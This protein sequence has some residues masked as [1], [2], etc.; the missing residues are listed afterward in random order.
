MHLVH[1]ELR[2]GARTQPSHSPMAISTSPSR[3]TS[4]R[5]V[6]VLLKVTARGN[7]SVGAT[8]N[9]FRDSGGESA[10]ALLYRPLIR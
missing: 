1:A 4:T 2:I 7:W 10:L 8:R 3:S 9:D 6:S 5:T